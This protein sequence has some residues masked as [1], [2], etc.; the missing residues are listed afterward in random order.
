VELLPVLKRHALHAHAP[1][2]LEV[3]RL[4]ARQREN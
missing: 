4:H 1:A 2:L 3:H